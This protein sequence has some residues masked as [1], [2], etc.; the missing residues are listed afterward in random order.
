VATILT[1][2]SST[3]LIIADV[4]SFGL[5]INFTDRIISTGK[6]LIGLGP[7]LFVLILPGF[8]IAFIIAKYASQFI[9]GKK[10]YGRCSLVLP[11]YQP[12]F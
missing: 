12:H 5:D 3:Q 7:G 8:S 4:Q 9:G 1:C 10:S 6:D 11:L 2:V